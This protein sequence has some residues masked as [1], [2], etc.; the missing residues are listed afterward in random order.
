ML[1]KQTRN[2]FSIIIIEQ[3]QRDE[4]IAMIQSN[5]FQNVAIIEHYM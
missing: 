4:I 2:E 5:K 3:Y 1:A